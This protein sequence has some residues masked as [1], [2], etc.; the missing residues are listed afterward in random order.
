[1][2]CWLKL[3]LYS[4]SRINTRSLSLIWISSLKTMGLF[5]RRYFKFFSIVKLW[6]ELF[7]LSI[8]TLPYLVLES[9]LWLRIVENINTRIIISLFSLQISYYILFSFIYLFLNLFLLFFSFTQNLFLS[10]IFINNNTLLNY[11]I[12]LI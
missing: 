3:L 5:N 10:V 9:C 11:D 8:I 2:I 12:I 6:E 1:M 7:L 4:F